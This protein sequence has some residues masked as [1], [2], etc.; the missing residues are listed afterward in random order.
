MRRRTRIFSGLIAL[1]ALTFS[2]AEGV[3]A[4]TCAPDMDMSH[5]EMTMAEPAEG[6]TGHDCLTDPQHDE[7]PAGEHT[8]QC[9]FGPATS[10]QACAAAA[11][12]PAR[13]LIIG[14]P[15]PEEAAQS[16]TVDTGPRLL[17]VISIFHP[18]KF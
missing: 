11:S 3:W 6:A 17:R 15:S 1:V 16:Q 4:S 10:T 2:L 14:P 12:M 13:I 8:P 5:A 7:S 18:P 9:P